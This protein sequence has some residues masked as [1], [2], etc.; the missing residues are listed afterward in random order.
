MVFLCEDN[1]YA[2][3]VRKHD[4]TAGELRR[5]GEPFGIPGFGCDGTDVDQ[6]NDAIRRAF[7]ITRDTSRPTLVVASVY[8]F[9]GHYEGDLDLYRPAAEKAEAASNL[10]PV[11]K[12]RQRLLRDGTPDEQVA[13]A[14]AMAAQS[15]I[16]W[17]AAARRRPL[18]RAETARDH[19]FASARG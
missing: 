10:D 17:F 18:P 15:V 19:V 4:S 1:G 6:V 16:G 11:L 9:R 7:A 14:D 5:R 8:R 3:S 12:L 13:G 2:I